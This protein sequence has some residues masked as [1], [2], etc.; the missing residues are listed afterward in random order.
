MSEFLHTIENVAV[1]VAWVKTA[2]RE[3]TDDGMYVWR[4]FVSGGGSYRVP[5]NGSTPFNPKRP[6][7]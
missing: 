4:V 5:D 7:A 3:K 6:C 2:V 1:N